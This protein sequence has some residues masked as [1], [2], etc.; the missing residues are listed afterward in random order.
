TRTSAP[1]R[2]VLPKVSR[3]CSVR[4]QRFHARMISVVLRRLIE[5]FGERRERTPEVD[6]RLLDMSAGKR[7]RL[8]PEGRLVSAERERWKTRQQPRDEDEIAPADVFLDEPQLSRATRE[9]R[10][11]GRYPGLQMDDLQLLF[12]R[13]HQFRPKGRR[14]ACSTR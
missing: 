13:H 14:K 12:A 9:R 6:Q 4:S 10:L 1:S 11:Q 5:V 8:L 2:S 7:G 3:Q